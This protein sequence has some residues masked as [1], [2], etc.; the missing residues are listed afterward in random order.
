MRILFGCKLVS[1]LIF[2]VFFLG[3]AQADE[4]DVV[5]ATIKET[6]P[7][8]YT[9]SAEVKHAD[10]GWDHYADGWEVVG[11]DGKVIATRELAHPHVNEQPFTR[12]KSGIRIPKG[13][14]E[15]TIRARDSVHGHGGKSVTLAVPGAEP[16]IEPARP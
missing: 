4:A 5:S 3:S 7:G 15:V 6:A 9:I 1:V 11:P 12:S 13:M 14:T 10:T 16:A 2:S 8:V